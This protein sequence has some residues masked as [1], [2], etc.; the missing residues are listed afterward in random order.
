MVSDEVDCVDCSVFLVDLTALREKH[1]SKCEEL[2]VLRVELAELQSRPTLL[3]ACTFCPAL[4][5]NIAEFHSRI[6]SLEADFKVLVPTSCSTCEL[7]AVKNLE[8]GQC[9][10]RQQT[11]NDDLQN[12][13]SWL[14]IQEPQLG[15][16]IE[17]FKRFDGQALG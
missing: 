16:M 9:V 2:D 4:L 12:L 5:E 15:M 14:S 1:A 13:L 8:L 17:A 11:E 10:D 3:G 7:H 6:V